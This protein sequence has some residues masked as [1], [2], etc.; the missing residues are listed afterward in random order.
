MLTSMCSR[1]AE[2]MCGRQ[3]DLLQLYD[4]LIEICLLWSRIFCVREVYPAKREVNLVFY[5]SALL[6]LT[7]LL[8]VFSLLAAH[9]TL[10]SLEV[11]VVF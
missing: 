11:C 3:A 10:I 6:L 2:W 8:A 4:T 9:V 1:T 5:L 7:T